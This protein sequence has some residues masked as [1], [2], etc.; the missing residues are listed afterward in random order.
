[1]QESKAEQLRESREILEQVSK[2]IE[3]ERRMALRAKQQKARAMQEIL[4]VRFLRSSAVEKT[5]VAHTPPCTV[6][7]ALHYPQSGG[8]TVI[9]S[10]ALQGKYR[11]GATTKCEFRL[12]DLVKL[13][14]GDSCGTPTS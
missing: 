8:G 2:D 7:I 5:W 14:P 6:L 12:M 10:T 3:I 9:L 11:R 13:P 4:E 1:M